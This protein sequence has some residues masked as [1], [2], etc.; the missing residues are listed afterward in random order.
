MTIKKTLKVK[1]TGS[2]AAA[3][4]GN[5]AVADRFR[6]DAPDPEA[7]KRAAAAGTGTKC[8]AIAGVIALIVVGVL[9]FI[10][11]KHCEFL[12]PE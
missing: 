8:A 6:L 9:T 4:A 10:L 7:A 2:P 11:Y 3:P 5:G 1:P 12:M